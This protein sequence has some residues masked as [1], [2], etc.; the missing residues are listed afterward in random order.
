VTEPQR[1]LSDILEAI[2]E[3]QKY[4]SRG[5][6]VFER[7]ELIQSWILLRLQI[8]GE[9][10]RVIREERPE[11]LW[12]WPDVPWAKIVGMRNRLVHDYGSIRHDI[13]W[14]TVQ[15]DL[16]LVRHAVSALLQA[17]RPAP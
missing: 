9:A 6:E 13:V 4:A 2:D 11:W 16:P 1:K 7:E 17:S 5:R 10:V 3:I 8:I 15:E 12:S 14:Q